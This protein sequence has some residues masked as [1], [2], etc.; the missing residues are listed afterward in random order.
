[1]LRPPRAEETGVKPHLILLLEA[2]AVGCFHE[3]DVLQQVGHSDGRVE[4]S[5]LI[6]RL[7]AFTVVPWNVQE[8]AV[9]RRGT[10]VVLI[11]KR[12]GGTSCVITGLETSKSKIKRLKSGLNNTHNN[13]KSYFERTQSQSVSVLHT[14]L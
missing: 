1:M 3:V 4:L 9:L 14:H 12:T 7:G 8:P 13:R 2:V 11:C 10:G 5:R 6:R